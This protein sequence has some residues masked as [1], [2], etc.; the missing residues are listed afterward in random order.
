M[1]SCPIVEFAMIISE[2]ERIW[3]SFTVSVWE[4]FVEFEAVSI[5]II[6]SGSIV[7]ATAVDAIDAD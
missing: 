4:I 5:E 7:L 6:A 2:Q 3:S 1:L